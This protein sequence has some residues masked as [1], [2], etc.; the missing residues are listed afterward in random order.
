LSYTPVKGD[1]KLRNAGGGVKF[2]FGIFAPG[3]SG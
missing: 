3:Q 2:C 1:V